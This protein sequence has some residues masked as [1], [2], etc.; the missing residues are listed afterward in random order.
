MKTPSACRNRP[1]SCRPGFALLVALILMAA[2]ML[3]AVGLLGLAPVSLR[4]SQQG[5]AMH[6]ARANARMALALAIGQLQKAAGPD[7]RVTAAA[8]IDS[9]DSANPHW[10]GVWKSGETGDPVWLVSGDPSSPAEPPSAPAMAL[11]TDPDRTVTVPTVSIRASGPLQGRC[12]WWTADEGVKARVDAA[13]PDDPENE[14]LRFARAR[15]SPQAA[16]ARIDPSLAAIDPEARNL[17]FSLPTVALAADKRDIPRDY[18]HDITTGGAALPVNI[19]EGG[20]KTDL[21]LVFDSSQRNSSHAREVLGASIGTRSASGFTLTPSVES[22]FYLLNEFRSGGRST[23]PNWG[24]LYNYAQLWQHLANGNAPVVTMQPALESD[25]RTNNW[26]PYSHHNKGAWARDIQHLNSTIQPVISNLHMGF[27]LRAKAGFPTTLGAPDPNGYQVQLDIKPVVGIWNPHNVKIRNTSYQFDWAIYPYLRIGIVGPDGKTLATPRIWMREHW[28]TGF[29]GN[30]AET[31]QERYFRLR[32]PVIDLEP[33][34]IRLFSVSEKADLASV[35]TLVPA[36]NEDGGFTFDLVTSRFESETHAGRPIIVPAGS[37]VWYGDLF[38]E[39]SQHEETAAQFPEGFT[40]GGSA[41]WV[42][43]KAGTEQAVQRISDIWTTPLKNERP[44]FRWSIP[45]Q[46]N[47]IY[48]ATGGA[49]TSPKI[50]VQQL[51]Q[52]P[53]HIGTWSWS[54]RTTTEAAG[55]QSLRGW[56][57]TNVRG[58]AANPR[59]DGSRI[60][61]SGAYEGWYFNSAML[62]GTFPY[63]T[64]G[65]PPGRGK[66]AEGQLG[67]PE[68]PSAGGDRYRGFGGP[69]T[70][71]TGQTHLTLFD[72][73]RGPLVSL[74]QFQ[75]AHLS[76][77]GHEPTYLFG[78]SYADP[79]IPPGATRAADHAGISGFNLND[80]PYLLNRRLW[81]EYFFS[82]IGVDYS[83]GQRLL[84]ASHPLDALAS[85]EKRLPNPRHRLHLRPGDESLDQIVRDAGVRAP[86]AIA[87]RILVEGAFNI[88]STSTAAW[89]AILSSMEDLEFPTLGTDGASASWEKPDGIRLPRFGHSLTPKGWESSGSADD[90]AFW[91]GFRTIGE[92]ELDRLAA[93][94]VDEVRARGPFTSLAAFVNRDPS[95]GRRQRQ[96][97]GALQAALD[98]TVNAA[99]P[100]PVGPPARQPAGNQF[101]PVVQGESQAAGYPGYVLQGDVLQ[102]LAPFLSPRSD[103]FRIRAVG[104]AL[105]A[106]GN[107]IARACCEAFVQRVPDYLDPADSAET[108]PAELSSPANR[109]YGRSFR[110]ESFR[111]L[112]PAEI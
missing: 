34:E 70:T 43:L 47:S 86:K 74:G 53:W 33:G 45:E 68:P 75:H 83:G 21:S 25:I 28:A 38:L 56:I 8:S 50:T 104:E 52:S 30:T 58:S 7:Q 94:I 63:S 2:L 4:E 62:G 16:L 13:S 99:L 5:A 97:K 39:D 15:V 108:P 57:D 98:D 24:I 31:S 92:D 54:A 69:S 101:H 51:A 55:N 111:W 60:G 1:P 36:W 105:D 37:R 95:S 10:T 46:V 77:Y 20:M 81:D 41:S 89:K 64:D 91:R 71:Y 100:A 112:S 9:A 102:A 66:V 29:G 23:G 82:T 106:S 14:R 48:Y 59:W 42:T 84:D 22:R 35:N 96:L 80:L 6:A 17:L 32:T 67:D 110:I 49:A 76:R 12:A 109:L 103:Y 61:P 18:I 90:P 88:N 93:A 3:V 65:G 26:R 11:V 87:S 19:A 72:V 73:P 85:G 79:R 44:R 27:R 40:D 107:V 78:S